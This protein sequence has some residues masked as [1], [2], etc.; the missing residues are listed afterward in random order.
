MIGKVVIG[1]QSRTE[2]FVWWL[3]K[4]MLL[5]HSFSMKHKNLPN[6]FTF[7]IPVLFSKT[8]IQ[9]WEV[10]NKINVKLK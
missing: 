1:I 3:F 5:L 6:S 10:R 7:Q 4:D 8:L 2:D 9:F